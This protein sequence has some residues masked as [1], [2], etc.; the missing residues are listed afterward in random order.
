MGFCLATAPF[1][2]TV[3]TRH[4]QKEAALRR[5]G[6]CEL[7]KGIRAS[8]WSLMGLCMSYMLPH[9]VHEEM[10]RK[11]CFPRDLGGQ[12]AKPAIL[13]IRRAP[14]AIPPLPSRRPWPLMLRPNVGVYRVYRGV[15]FV[16]F[17]V[18]GVGVWVYKGVGFIEFWHGLL[19]CGHTVQVA[20]SVTFGTA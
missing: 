3:R 1:R 17:W 9:L 6:Y 15:G 16:E 19:N 18:K 14:R 7:W 5:P 4:V 10:F 20:A 11:L 2:C 12:P 13:R 8:T